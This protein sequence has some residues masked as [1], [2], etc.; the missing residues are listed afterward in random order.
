MS[1]K[2]IVIGA[3]ASGMLAAGNA[4]LHGADVLLLE[5]KKTPGNKLLI[6]GKGRCNLTN[7]SESIDFIQHFNREGQFLHQPF[8]QFFAPH[9]MEFFH[10][11]G[12]ELITERG[13][14]VFPAS[15]KAEEIVNVLHTWLKSSGVVVQCSSKVNK[16]HVREDQV[17]G[18]YCNRQRFNCD[19]VILATGGASYPATG[20][21]G[22]GYLMAEQLGHSVTPLRPGLVPLVI[23]D[24]IIEGLA[25]LDLRN[26]GFR[27]YVNGKRKCVDF[28][29]VG[30]TR[31]GIGGPLT[32]THSL[33]I[34]DNLKAGREVVISLDL[35]PALDEQKLDNRLQRDFTQRHSENLASVLRGVLPRQLI[36][37]AIHCCS[38]NGQKCVG[39]LTTKERKRLRQWLKNFRLPISGHRPLSEAII[40]AGGIK[41]K[42]VNPNTM[43]SKLVHGLYIVGELLDIHGDTGGYNLQAAF[44]TGWL[45]GYNAAQ[46]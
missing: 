39:N 5:K 2:V 15:G 44:S 32:L 18:V 42:E 25:G 11:L 24:P 3:G 9:L 17:V 14:R 45:A 6:S 7:N 27:V 43:E 8:S 13:G 36:Q 19:A 33:N 4:A 46:P 37:T 28:G 29:E 26:T 34:V 23:N 12:V 21:T 16:V 30:F 41:V 31:F 40:T 38:L 20:S 22:D 35:K 1:K 10:N